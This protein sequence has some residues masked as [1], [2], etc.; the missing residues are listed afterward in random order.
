MK[1]VVNILFQTILVIIVLLPFIYIWIH[2]GLF[3]SKWIVPILPQFKMHWNDEFIKGLPLIFRDGH[4]WATF[5]ILL[6]VNK[7]AWFGFNLVGSEYIQ[8]IFE[9]PEPKSTPWFSY[10]L[11][12]IYT[13]VILTCGYYLFTQTD[14]ILTYS[15]KYIWAFIVL[16]LIFPK[17]EGFSGG[18]GYGGS[19]SCYVESSHTTEEPKQIEVK[20]PDQIDYRIIEAKEFGGSVMWKTRKCINGKPDSSGSSYSKHGKLIN[21]T[22]Y[23]ITIDDGSGW[24]RTFGI[25]GNVIN[26]YRRN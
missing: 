19:S 5:S 22:S 6:I 12:T 13:L 7:I 1:K 25:N 2:L 9:W 20:Q 18:G 26:S 24:I 14:V 15:G 11:L 8:P 21:W 17:S 16:W 4:P 3:I 10:T 23:D